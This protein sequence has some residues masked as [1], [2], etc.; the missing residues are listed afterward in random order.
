MFPSAEVIAITMVNA[1]TD[2]PE[3][4]PSIPSSDGT[5]FSVQVFR[6]P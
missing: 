3:S 6:L 1:N 4:V 5:S 2:E